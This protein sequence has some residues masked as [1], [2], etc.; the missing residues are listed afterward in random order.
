[1]PFLDS[2]SLRAAFVANLLER[3][4]DQI[5]AQGEELLRDAGVEFPPRAASTVLMLGERGPSSAAD[6]A[7]SL[8]HPHQLVTQRIDLLIELGI[9]ARLDD[10]KDARRKVVSL[11][12]KG[13]RQFQ[14]L[15]APLTVAESAF[16]ALFKEIG[17]DLAAAALKAMEALNRSSILTRTKQLKA[18]T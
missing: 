3:L 4:A 17:C 15:K 6:I 5:M 7:K 18:L 2:H 16:E 11:T 10:P 14:K 1:M 9:V 12:A 8:A 13:R